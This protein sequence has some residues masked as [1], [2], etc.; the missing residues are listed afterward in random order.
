M[1]QEL[2]QSYGKTFAKDDL[3]L[4]T[5]DLSVLYG[6]KVQKLF[7]ASLQFKKN[8]ITAL[9]GASGSGKSTFLRSLNRMND[10]VATV[11]GEIWFHGL[12]VNKPNINVYE[13]RKNIGMVFQ[14][15]NPFPK[16]IRENIVYALK[17]DGQT[18][19]AELD[20][21]VEES[22]RAAALWDEVKDKLDKSALALSGGQQQ[23]LCIARALAVK[24]EVLLLDEP[25]SALDP[26][27]TSKLEDT[28]K[29]LRSKYTMIMVTHNMQQAS[30]I[31]DYTAFFHLGHVI[32]Y[33]ATAD[34]F[35]NP[36]GKI[37][38]EY[39][40]GSFG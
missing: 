14:R 2:K 32:E 20:K 1:M 28:L 23:R 36:K 34:I 39:I 3:E 11:N 9:I 19:K 5:K 37:T 24:P 8:T 30:R 17:A 31:S 16:S 4:S 7:D 18:N 38:E 33:N 10:R 12:D 15:P 22:L 6:G 26:V 29:Q 13:L 40:Q 21:I 27:S 35:T 25:A